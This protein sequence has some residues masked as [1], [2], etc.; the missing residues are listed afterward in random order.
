MNIVFDMNHLEN[1]KKLNN[2]YFVLRH[3]ESKANV[4][5]VIVTSLENGLKE[6]YSLSINGEEQVMISVGR[7]KDGGFLDEQTIIYSS[8][9]SRTKKTAEIAKK[10]L[11]IE[12]K[13][14]FDERLVERFFGDLEGMDYSVHQKIWDVDEK[15]PDHKEKNVEST[16]E[17]LKRMTSV[18]KDLEEKYKGKKIL[19]ISHGDPLRILQTGFEKISSGLHK[20]F[21]LKTAEIKKM[22]LK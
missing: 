12:E 3:G 7:A 18:I 17:V 11:G 4:S 14:N 6:E 19:L 22:E 20:Q 2:D 5:K 8:P 10:V 16:R 15:N 1:L 13:I 9:F 21:S